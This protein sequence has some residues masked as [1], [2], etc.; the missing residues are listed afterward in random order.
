M[1]TNA[2]N[3]LL[4]TL[5]EPAPRTLL[6]LVTSRPSRLLADAAQPLPARR[7]RRAPAPAQASDVARPANSAPPRRRPARPRRRRAAAGA[8]RCAPHFDDLESQMTGTARG[9]CSAGAVEVTARGRGHAGRGPA[10]AARLAGVLAGHGCAGAH[11][12]G[13]DAAHGSGWPVVAK[14]G[15]R[16]EHKRRVPDGGPV[17][18]SR[19]LLE[20]SARR[21]TGRR[22]PAR[23]AAGRDFRRR[24]VA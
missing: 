16:S 14:G 13:C 15:C 22:G 3:A 10:G 7:G 18:R 9:R 19:R 1:T 4:K 2:Q 24:G 12:A 17:A 8:A 6:V 23:R 11:A 21:S 20:G 5:E